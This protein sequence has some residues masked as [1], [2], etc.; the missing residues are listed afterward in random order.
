MLGDIVIYKQAAAGGGFG[1]QKFNASPSA[2][3][4]QPGEPVFLVAGATSVVPN[5]ATNLITIP[6][7]YV[8][9]S[10][11]GTGLAG[12]AETISTNSSSAAGIVEV[13]PTSSLTVYLITA[14][15]SY[16]VATQAR[17]DAN[18]GKRVLIDLT[19]GSYTLLTTDSALNGCIIRPLDVVK[20][21]GKFA[22]S[23]SDAIAA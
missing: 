2:G 17:Y 9:F 18:V 8:P 16:Q 11:T 20:F 21:P 12:I 22:F 15:S 10:V 1:S 23:F 14:N 4:I 13:N 19:T 5:Q 6:S 7:P 3:L